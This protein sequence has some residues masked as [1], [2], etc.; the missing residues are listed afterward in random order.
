MFFIVNKTK[1]N[2]IIGDLG[3]PLGPKQAIDLDKI[4]DRS[5]SDKS[6]SLQI[7]K[8]RGEIE[9]RV[10]DSEKVIN[11]VEPKKDS[12]DMQ[13]IKKEI[14]DE[15]KI[16]MKEIMG[17]QKDITISDDFLEKFKED[18][19][20]AI[21]TQSSQNQNNTNNIFN[22]EEV[23][24]SDNTLASINAKAVEKMVKN[25]EVKSVNYKEEQC[26]DT[27]LSNIDELEELLG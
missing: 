12:S 26:H 7:A 1:K 13:K 3:L 9:I 11:R 25:A 10:K 5:K 21:P 19:L 18:I 8:S 2:I 6:Q 20:K 23:Q 14:V 22:D 4:M 15:M 17:N 16:A 27:I 24:V